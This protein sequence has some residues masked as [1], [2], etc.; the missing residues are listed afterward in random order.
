MRA[1][2]RRDSHCPRVRG[3]V[4]VIMVCPF[5]WLGGRLNKERNSSI[6]CFTEDRSEGEHSN[7]TEKVR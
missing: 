1:Q 7:G 3:G 6:A 2:A 5:T 4:T